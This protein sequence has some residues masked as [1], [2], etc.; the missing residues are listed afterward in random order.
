MRPIAI[1]ISL[2]LIGLFP[3]R[4]ASQTG[5]PVHADV[6]PRPATYQPAPLYETATPNIAIPL[7]TEAQ[8]DP[9][10]GMRLGPSQSNKSRQQKKYDGHGGL[11]SP[12]TIGGSLALVI[13]VFLIVAY[14]M[15]RAAPR[16]GGAL[17]HEVFE[18][19]GRAPLAERQHVHLLRCGNKLLLVSVTP[20]G[21]ETLTEITAAEEVERLSALCHQTKSGSSTANFRQ[22]FQQ[23]SRGG[24]DE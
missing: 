4:T 23:L 13:G 11:P 19:F 14:L 6:Q 16:S 15:R 7:Q 22:V 17:P 1:I 2:L 9:T 5:L 24:T 3:S 18:V 8:K 20:N 21:T 10:V 12:V